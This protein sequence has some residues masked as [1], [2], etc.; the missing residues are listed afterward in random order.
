MT[1]P[2]ETATVPLRATAEISPTLA[3]SVTNSSTSATL[4][5]YTYGGEYIYGTDVV[6]MFGG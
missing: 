6:D 3:A 4:T 2:F 1:S 5:G